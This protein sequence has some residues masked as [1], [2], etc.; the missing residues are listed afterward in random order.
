MNFTASLE[1]AFQ[2]NSNPEN[3]FAMA[4]YMRDHF[5]FFGIKTDERR[6]ILKEIC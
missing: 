6:L 4:K 5:S 2:E 3:A 1:S